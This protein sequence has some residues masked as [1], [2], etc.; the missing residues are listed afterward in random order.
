ML[1]ETYLVQG[2]ARVAG[3][4]EVEVEGGVHDLL[5][6]VAEGVGGA[7]AAEAL[8]DKEDAVDEQAV[9]GPLDLEVAEEGVGAEEGED[10][11]EDV[12]RLRVRVRRL[13]GGQGGVR[14]WQD[15]GW[16]ARLG[17][18]GEEGHVSDQAREGRVRV[19]HGVVGLF[20]PV[21]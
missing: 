8:A 15:V 19:E 7:D 14:R 6:G 21:G 2:E 12:V 13:A 4:G 17:A 11:V 20:V 9:G 16:P 3:D 1:L 10:L 18:Q 5:G